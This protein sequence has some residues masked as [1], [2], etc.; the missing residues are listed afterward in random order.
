MSVQLE[1]AAW[2]DPSNDALFFPVEPEASK[3]ESQDGSSTVELDR[4]AQ[5]ANYDA[6]L[7]G[8]LIM[9]RVFR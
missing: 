1:T 6:A 8:S 9:S 2:T 7:M 5:L 4:D 3:E